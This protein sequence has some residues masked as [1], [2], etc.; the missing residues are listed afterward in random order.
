M[1]R[2]KFKRKSEKNIKIQKNRVGEI[3]RDKQCD[4]G[5]R[6]RD[7]HKDRECVK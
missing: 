1:E 5:Q 4:G 2:K 7:V 3:H 6:V